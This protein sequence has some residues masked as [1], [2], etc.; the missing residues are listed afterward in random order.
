VA[1]TLLAMSND[2]R[3]TARIRDAAVQCFAEFGFHGTSTRSIA[4][5]LNMSAAA[6]YPHYRSKEELLFDIVMRGS[7]ECLAAIIAADPDGDAAT[8]LAAVVCTLAQW[9]AEHTTLARVAQYELS[10]LSDAHRRQV[11][12]LR[13]RISAEVQAII[14]EGAASGALPTPDPAGA[15]LAIC[16]LCIDVCRWFPSRTHTDPSALGLQYADLA[17]RM[18]GARATTPGGSTP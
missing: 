3:A 18:V 14:T 12:R 15:T 2:S 11:S 17:L 4:A 6:L 8:R 1:A 7:E 10:A 16:S 9:H 5:R 13:A